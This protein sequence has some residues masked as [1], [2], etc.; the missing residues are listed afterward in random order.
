MLGKKLN[1]L[2][3]S[4]VGYSLVVGFVIT[5][6]VCAFTA[7]D[8]FYDGFEAL[9]YWLACAWMSILGYGVPYLIVLGLQKYLK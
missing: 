5:I 8:L 9:G 7:G 6:I 1:N 2:I 4:I 3:P